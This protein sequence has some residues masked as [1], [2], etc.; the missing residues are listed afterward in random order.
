MIFCDESHN[1]SNPASKIFKAV[2]ALV[3][4][5]RWCLS[6]TPIKNYDSDLLSQ[7]RFI[8]YNSVTKPSEWKL[9]GKNFFEQH[10]LAERVFQMS[11]I[12]VSFEMPEKEESEKLVKLEGK[13]KEIYDLVFDSINLSFDESYRWCLLA[14]LTR[15]RQCL[16]APY[17]MTEESKRNKY[18][19][20]G[21]DIKQ[22]SSSEEV[23][24]ILGK[25]LEKVIPP[26][27]RAWCSNK[28]EAGWK[29]P[30]IV[31]TFGLIDQILEL[32]EK[33]II[34]STQVAALDLIADLLEEDYRDY[35]SY[36]QIDGSLSTVKR[37][38]ALDYFR[39]QEDCHILLASYKVCSEGL[40]LTEASFCI[41]LDFWWNNAT[42]DQAVSR[43]WRI[44]QTKPVRVFSIFAEDTLDVRIEE[45]C[46]SKEIIASKYKTK[47]NPSVKTKNLVM[48]TIGRLLGK[49]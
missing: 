39:A 14:L 47:K 2:M 5:Y 32:G 27:L 42:R 33:V 22:A 48:P 46:K 36:R 18:S 13:F 20:R 40:N 9:F 6:G 28:R 24:T 10:R 19:R 26:R 30:K 17:L 37:A 41:L 21:K 31:A 7:L 49:A 12:D 44:G 43:L 35:T 11:Y 25:N 23:E 1:F 3:G 45:I 16:V 8:G 4:E 29:A 38:E 34:F 15:I